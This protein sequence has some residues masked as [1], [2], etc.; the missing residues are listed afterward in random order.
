MIFVPSHDLV[1]TLKTVKALT[2]QVY[3][4]LRKLTVQTYF[5]DQKPSIRNVCNFI[6]HISCPSVLHPRCPPWFS[7]AA[8]VPLNTV[9]HF[10]FRA[11]SQQK[12]LFAQSHQALTTKFKFQIE[13]LRSRILSTKP[14][15][16]AIWKRACRN[17]MAIYLRLETKWPQN[18]R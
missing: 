6:Q 14:Q 16:G 13:F 2:Y 8:K 4:H 9:H 3:I 17:K 18:S 5:I 11:C 10:L 12:P 1:F 7:Y 15:Q